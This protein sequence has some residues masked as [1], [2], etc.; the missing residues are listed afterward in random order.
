VENDAVGVE[1]IITTDSV[2]SLLGK[3]NLLMRE[4]LRAA[5][6]ALTTV[7]GLYAVDPRPDRDAF[8]IDNLKVIRQ[9]EEA[10]GDA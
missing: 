1:A 6:H 10:L 9:I 2:V 5:H 7:H 4:A 8:Q 3:E